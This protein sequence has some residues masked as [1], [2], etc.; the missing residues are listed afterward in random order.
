MKNFIFMLFS[1][2]LPLSSCSPAGFTPSEGPF[3]PEGTH[4]THEMIVLGEQLEDPYSVDNMTKALESLYP[5]KA[6]RVRLDPTH[7]YMRFLPRDEKE[8]NMLTARGI[9]LIDHPVD[10]RIV[11]EGDYYHDPTVREGSITWQYSVIPKDLSFPQTIRHEVLDEC[12]IPSPTSTKAYSEFDWDAIERQ[13]FVLSGN[14]DMLAPGSKG[15]SQSAVPSGRI[16]IVDN[17][18]PDEVIGLKGAKVSCNTFVKF[19][20]CFTDEEGNYAMKTKFSSN[21]RYRIVFKS[22]YGFG[23]GFNLILQPASAS[24]LGTN[25]PEGLDVQITSASERKLFTRSVVNNAAYDYYSACKSD[26]SSIKAPP[27]NLRIWLFRNLKMSS[28]AMFQQGVLIDDGVVGK[29]L[30]EYT[31]LLKL[32]L[33]DIT[34]GLRDAAEY[35][36]IYSLATHELAHTSHFMLVGKDYWNSYADF[37]LRS[38]VTSGFVCYGTGLEENHGY[39]EIGEMWAYYIQSKFYKERYPQSGT[40]FGTNYWF[41]PQILL[42]LDERGLDHFKLYSALGKDITDSEMLQKKLISLY[43]Q[44]KSTINQAFSRY[45]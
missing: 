38:F 15:D 32:F 22:R 27:A 33:P 13:S 26:K 25:S 2:A 3:G 16:T 37:I 45:H 17:A 12:Y 41:Y 19:D 20:S 39:C 8:Y 24:T 40:V 5:T 7:V 6:E 35:S 21:P 1:I 10:Y 31:F 9:E 34:L 23:I 18:L 36:D 11:R 29:Y 30:G 42:Y 14:S 28:A 43:P 4:S 44:M